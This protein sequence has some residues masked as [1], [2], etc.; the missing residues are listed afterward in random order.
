MTAPSDFNLFLLL[1]LDPEAAW[2]S[3]DFDRRLKEKKSGWAKLVNAPTAKGLAARRNMELVQHP[4]ISF[5][6]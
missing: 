2:S 5:K 1:E 4:V 3:S 6:Y